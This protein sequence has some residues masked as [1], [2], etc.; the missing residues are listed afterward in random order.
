VVRLLHESGL[1]D[2]KTLG[3]LDEKILPAKLR[4]LLPTL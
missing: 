2:G 1:P 3:N 4:R